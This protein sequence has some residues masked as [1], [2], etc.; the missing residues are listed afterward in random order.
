MEQTPQFVVTGITIGGTYA[1]VAIGFSIIFNATRILN[2]AQGEFSMLAGLL[3]ASLI[4]SARFPMA[5]GIAAAIA[6][7]GL[8]GMA[9]YRI[10]IRPVSGQPGPAIL[11]TIAASIIL[12]GLAGIVWG[13]D[14]YYTL[15]PLVSAD[16]IHIF[17]AV[18]VSQHVVVLIAVASSL[19]A[20]EL[21]FHRTLTG[22]AIR[23][24]SVNPMLATLLGIPVHRIT[25]YAFVLSAILGAVAGVLLAPL[26]SVGYGIGPTL[27]LKG[28]AAT[29][30]GGM[31]SLSGSAAGGL[32]LGL[33][34]SLAA[35][36]LPSGYKDGIAFAII[37]L[38][39]FLRPVGDA[40]EAH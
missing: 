21:F 30:L 29:I 40:R 38:F 36:L 24:C 22:R 23:A 28:F 33:L 39:L 37:L 1:I 19:V 7:T 31:S 9:F 12:T 14:N 25:G 27:T 8:L 32:A 4:L 35:G 18:L 2:F 16:P 20:L 5:L 13:K 3:A 11:V 34:E 10:L 15:P 17:G 26:A 6:I